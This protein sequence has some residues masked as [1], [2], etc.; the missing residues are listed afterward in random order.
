MTK[1]KSYVH[2]YYYNVAD[3]LLAH[4]TVAGYYSWRNTASG[5]WFIQVRQ[6]R[7]QSH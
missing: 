3:F 2:D 5:S 1:S 4:S 6:G 7:Q